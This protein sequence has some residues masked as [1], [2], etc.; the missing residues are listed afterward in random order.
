MATVNKVFL[1]GNLT[2]DPEV[3]HLPSGMAV[4]DITLALNRQWTDK[5]SGQRREEVSFVDVTMFGR[6]AEIAGEYLSKGR[7][8]HVEG[9]LR[10]EKWQDKQT[11]G[12]RSKI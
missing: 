1:I 3:K 12:N 2:R 7:Q 5:Q 10:Q 6:T 8:C 11:G 4:C 9:Q